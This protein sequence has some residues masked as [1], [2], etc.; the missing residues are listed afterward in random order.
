MPAAAF[1]GMLAML[2][3]PMLL[4]GAAHLELIYVG[5][6]PLFLWTWIRL[7]DRPGAAR[8]AAAAGAYLLVAVCAAYFAVYAVFPAALYFFWKGWA[9][10][11]TTAAG[12]AAPGVVRRPRPLAA[13]V[14][15]AGG[16]RARGGLRQPDLGDVAG[17]RAAPIARRVPRLRR[18]ALELRLPDRAARPGPARPGSWYA[19][20]GLGARTIE[21]CS[22][23]GVVSL[24][25][26]AY[27]AAFRV[28]FRERVVLVGLPGDARR[29]GRGRRVDHRRPRGHPAR[30]LAQEALRPVPDDPGP[31]A[32]Q[33]VR[34]GRRGP[35]G[36]VRPA[37]PADAPAAA[38]D[39]R[40]GAG[41]R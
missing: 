11:S 39:A 36:R 15:G 41:G 29:A 40:G 20:G 33:P 32:V 12:F 27:A 8:L 38:M 37:P 24:A 1:G 23:L 13:G 3:A 35:G 26:V 4:H 22:Y 17:L 18:P 5:A 6:F 19:E 16:A 7:L 9:A 10:A 31:V 2:S 14:L 34:G 30:A 25:L 21:C 28:R